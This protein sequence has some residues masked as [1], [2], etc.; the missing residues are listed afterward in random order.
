MR[1]PSARG[2]VRP[3]A[4][5]RSSRDDLRPVRPKRRPLSAINAASP[6]LD[7]RVGGII[8]LPAQGL[9]E[10]LRSRFTHW[11]RWRCRTRTRSGD[12]PRCG[13]AWRS[14]SLTQRAGVEDLELP[15]P[16]PV[17]HPG[18]DELRER[19]GEA[20]RCDSDGRCE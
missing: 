12:E 13:S 4:F 20:L 8:G 9:V 1:R 16:E 14:R 18:L 5:V 15:R 7:I 19:T 3:W 6:E 10:R 17:E 11:Y 2:R